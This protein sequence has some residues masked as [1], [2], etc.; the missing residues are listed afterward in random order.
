MSIVSTNKERFVEAVW[1]Y[2]YLVY[3]AIEKVIDYLNRTE[4]IRLIDKGD[5]LAFIR[6]NHISE[7]LVNETKYFFHGSGCT[8]YQ[9]N[10]PIV[11]W[12]FGWGNWPCGIDPYKMAVTLKGNNY[13]DVD[14][15]DFQNIK[16]LCRLFLEEGLLTSTGAQYYLDL[17]ALNKTKT[18]FP[19]DFDRML[20]EYEGAVVSIERNKIV[21]RFL[22]KSPYIYAGIDGLKGNRILV[23]L[24][25]EKEIARVP[26]NDIAYPKEAVQ[27]MRGELRRL[28]DHGLRSQGPL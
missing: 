22:R 11:L 2:T 23:F 13:L 9:N 7:V 21:D 1:E 26:Y 27:I 15:H 10:Q 14:Y 20:I 28:M 16:K 25:G 24:K 5:L 4:G 19:V 3:E 12:D 18:V 6:E 17:I 8:V